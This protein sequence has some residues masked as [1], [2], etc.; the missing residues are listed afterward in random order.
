MMFVKPVLA[1][2]ASA[3]LLPIVVLAQDGAQ[4]PIYVPFDYSA[5]EPVSASIIGS[6]GGATT[7][8]LIDGP[9]SLRVAPGPATLIKNGNAASMIYV[10]EAIPTATYS[11]VCNLVTPVAM[12][13]LNVQE[14]GA[15][16]PPTGGGNGGTNTGR[17]SGGNNGGNTG[18]AS[19]TGVTALFL[20]LGTAVLG[21]SVGVALLN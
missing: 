5:G 18:G 21:F 2:V 16:L 6:S 8:A 10:N 12:C 3:L 14:S 15:P 13:T 17:P 11:G 20:G 7:Y 1:V 9:R 4:D 19:G